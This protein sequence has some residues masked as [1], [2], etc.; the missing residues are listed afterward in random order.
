MIGGLVVLLVMGGVF[1][2]IDRGLSVA[3][4]IRGGFVPEPDS[5]EA[6]FVER[7]LLTFVHL[8]PA[9][10]FVLAGPLQFIRQVRRRWPVWHRWV[11]RVFLAAG[12]LM[13]YSSIHL[14]LNRAFGG[15]SEAAATVIFAGVLL[16]CL[17]TA[18]AHI[19][20]RRIREHREWMI[21]SF[22]IGIAVVTIRPVVGLYLLLTEYSTQEIL[23]TA[24]WI[25]FT[26]HLIAAEI[27][28]RLT[29]SPAGGPQGE[30]WQSVAG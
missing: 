30:G 29:G 28:I 13:A 21:R 4:A 27:W 8:V 16:G 26:L 7:P 5:F 1:V 15:P 12:V 22:V 18:F 6:P 23:G 24:F 25:S 10:V 3:T 17:G 19:R 2:V 9:L 14:V 20:N 11:G